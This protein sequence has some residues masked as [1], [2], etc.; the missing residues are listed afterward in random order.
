MVN[1]QHMRR[2]GLPPFPL[3]ALAWVVAGCS[4]SADVERVEAYTG[5]GAEETVRFAG[6][7]PFW[8]GEVTGTQL[9]YSDPERAAGVPIPVE[10]FAGNGGLS[11]SGVFEGER[12]DL[13]ITPGA[14][15]DT[16]ADRT[17][18]FTATLSIEGETRFG[19]AWTDRQPFEEQG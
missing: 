13:A 9:R 2:T 17:Y 19:C 5:I 1:P 16:M 11:F 7:E 4:G 18:P 8:G 14:C 6:N 3:F 12:F 10:R 15:D